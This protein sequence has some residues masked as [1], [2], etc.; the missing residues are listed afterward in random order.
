[1]LAPSKKAMN[2]MIK[3]CL[4]ENYFMVSSVSLQATHLV[5]YAHIKLSPLITD[6]T[7]DS[8][9]TGL[10]GSMGNK[11]SVKMNFKLAETTMTFINSHLHSG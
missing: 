8:L 10:K 9:A 6:V 1:M 3:S 2:E 5:V 7:T 11:G 4:G